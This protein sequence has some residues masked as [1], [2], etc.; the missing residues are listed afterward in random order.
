MSGS[1]IPTVLGRGKGSPG[2]GPPLPFWPLTVSLRT[3]VVPAGVSYAK[4]LQ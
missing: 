2:I 1:I 4:V 3:V